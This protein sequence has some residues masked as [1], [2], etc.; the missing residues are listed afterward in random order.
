MAQPP[1]AIVIDLGRLPSHGRGLALALRERK[2]TR[3]VPLVFVDGEPEKV[4]RL[5]ADL[6]DAV[7][8]TWRGING[9]LLRAV[10]L[11]PASPVVYRSTSGAYSGTPLPRKLGVKE[12]G[13]LALLGAPREFAATLGELPPGVKVTAKARGP[14]DT[15]VL[16]AQSAAALERSLA[17]AI[18]ALAPKG[19][20]WIAWPKKASGVASDL[21][22]N[23]VR[24]RGLATGLVDT[25]VCAI[26]ATWSGLRFQRRR[27]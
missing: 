23:R 11:Q 24:E 4:G 3:H 12:E 22:E 20:L 9:A 7:Y 15:I 5:R 21:D 25:K 27:K 6:P 16:F 26:D 13:T 14:A 8:T 1:D 10:R 17:R 18:G 2:T 19:S